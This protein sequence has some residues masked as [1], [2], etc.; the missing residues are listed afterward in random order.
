MRTT[1]QMAVQSYL[2][3]KPLSRRTRNEYSSTLK[4]WEQFGCA[5]PIEEWRRK[6]IRE[7][8]DWVHDCAVTDGGVNPGRTANISKP[9]FRGRENKKSSRR[10]PASRRRAISGTSRV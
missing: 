9:S 3:A 8:L 5:V 6:D 1:F 10:R 2:R 7:F 4:K